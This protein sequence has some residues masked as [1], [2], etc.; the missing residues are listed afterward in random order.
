[1]SIIKGKSYICNKCGKIPG[2]GCVLYIVGV[3]M[4]PL[5]CPCDATLDA[6]FKDQTEMVKKKLRM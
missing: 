2:Q 4:V 3:P 5:L 1:M 6:M